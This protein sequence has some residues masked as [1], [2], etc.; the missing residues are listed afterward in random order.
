MWRIVR[1]PERQVVLD[2]PG[3]VEGRGAYVCRT[4]SCLQRALKGRL[5]ERALRQALPEGV[6]K[7]LAALCEEYSIMRG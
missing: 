3:K 1:T 7:D 2:L 6:S 5:F 4:S